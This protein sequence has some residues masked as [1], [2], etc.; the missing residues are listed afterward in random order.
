MQKLTSQLCG[1]LGESLALAKLVSLGLHAY[2]S[3]PG[4]PGH[5]LVVNTPTGI[6][7]VEVKTRQFIDRVSEISRWPVSLATKGDA[8]FFIFV[9]LSLRTMQ[10]MFYLLTNTQARA[11]HKDYEGGGNCVPSKVRKL[12][13]PNDFS[14]LTVDG[15]ET[16]DT[17]A[18]HPLRKTIA[19]Q[20]TI[21]ELRVVQY[22]C[23]S[24]DVFKND[25]LAAN[26]I[27]ILRTIAGPLGVS[28]FNEAGGV[29]NTRQLG[30]AVLD[31]LGREA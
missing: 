21:D 17:G 8:D 14:S 5:D 30:K 25:E 26:T 6:R 4:A 22:Q 2:A 24:I 10:P 16:A 9:E 11:V 23:N 27:G 18:A 28:E 3:P 19:R 15:S 31:A 12:I 20:Q 7:S 1:E 13:S 29:R